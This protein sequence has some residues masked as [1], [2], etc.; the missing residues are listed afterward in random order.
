MEKLVIGMPAGS[1]A[2][3][4]RGGSLVGLL[5]QA[6]FETSGYEKGGPSV[7]KTVNFLYGWDGRPQEFG[8]QM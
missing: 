8:S 4:N 6:G 2:D 3:P 5:A 7:F 1:L